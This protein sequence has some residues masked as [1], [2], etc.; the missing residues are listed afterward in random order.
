MVCACCGGMWCPVGK[1]VEGMDV[2][3]EI[4][5]CATT[6]DRP[7]VPIMMERIEIDGL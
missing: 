6:A 5:N 4:N 3:H 1:V 2:V 7:N